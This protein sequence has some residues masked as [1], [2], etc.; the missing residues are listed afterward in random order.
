M[1]RIAATCILVALLAAAAG[2]SAEVDGTHLEVAAG[3]TPVF[4]QDPAYA[5][6]SADDLRA[7]RF[8]LDLRV[9]A[10]KLGFFRLVPYLGYRV[11]VDDGSPYDVMDTH[12]G[13]HDF[14]GGLRVRTWFRSSVGAFL[15]VQGGVTYLKMSGSLTE[16]DLGPGARTEYS[17]R[18]ATWL[19]GGLL[20]VELRLPPAIF[21]RRGI[22]WLDFGLEIGGGY[23]RRGE[24]DL[25]PELEG[26]DE[27]SLESGGTADWG[28]LNLSG[29]NL[30]VMLTV[31]LF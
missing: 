11:G 4:V 22:D 13:A 6:F 15:D 28:G 29:W 10:A 17:D 19:V 21:K 27:Y 23:L 5:A 26:G 18:A 12:I 16:D 20:G 8:G 24:M 14:V 31:S 30:Q 1:T 7:S 25:D 3:A 2:A 9:E